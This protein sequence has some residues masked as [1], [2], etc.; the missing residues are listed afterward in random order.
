MNFDIPM[1]IPMT[2]EKIY[3]IFTDILKGYIGEN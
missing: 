1:P 3:K 2:K